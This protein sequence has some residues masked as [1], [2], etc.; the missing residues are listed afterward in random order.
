ML[1]TQQT[2]YAGSK[3]MV[4]GYDAP[5]LVFY[6]SDYTDVST[7]RGVAGCNIT[8]PPREGFQGRCRLL[9][10]SDTAARVHTYVGPLSFSWKTS[11]GSFR[12]R[13]VEPREVIANMPEE[14]SFRGSGAGAGGG[15]GAFAA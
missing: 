15:R 7:S 12:D 3:N 6:R 11:T 2:G 10:F 14:A 8:P 4:V 1:R 5:S 13:S 9:K